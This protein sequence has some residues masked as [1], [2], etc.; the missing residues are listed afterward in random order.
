MGYEPGVQIANCADL[1][2]YVPACLV[3]PD[4]R[5]EPCSSAQSSDIAR[6][7]TSASKH[8]IFGQDPEHRDR[9]FRRNRKTK[10]KKIGLTKKN[11]KRQLIKEKEQV[12]NHLVSKRTF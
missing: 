12:L 6:N 1:R 10:E 2:G 5:Y 3:I 9:R 7:I 4:Y 8:D 11:R